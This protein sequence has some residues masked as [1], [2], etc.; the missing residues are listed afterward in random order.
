MRVVKFKAYIKFLNEIQDV[1]EL[2]D[3]GG[4]MV[5]DYPYALA[6]DDIFLKQFTGLQDKGGVDIYEGDIVEEMRLLHD[7]PCFKNT[8]VKYAAPSFRAGELSLCNYAGIEWEV[9]GNIHQN[10]E[11][12]EDKL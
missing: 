7:G 11:L 5:S 4:C 10:P 9:I 6:H 2:Y 1:I 8:V 12:I 3:D